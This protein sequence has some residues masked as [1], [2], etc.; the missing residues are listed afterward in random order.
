MGREYSQPVRGLPLAV[1]GAAAVGLALVGAPAWAACP[2]PA[3]RSD[4][5]AALDQVALARERGSPVGFEVA[6]REVDAVVGCLQEPLEA[7]LARELHR[8]HGRAREAAGL[9]KAAVPYLAAGEAR[10][11]PATEPHLAEALA[12][13]RA[14]RG[15]RLPPPLRGQLLVDGQTVDLRPSESEPFVFQHVVGERIVATRY[16][17]PGAELPAYA[18][19]RGRL[20]LVG[21]TSLLLSGGCL[22]VAGLEQRRLT[23]P[24]DTPFTAAELD[25]LQAR[26]QGFVVGAGVT[27]AV[28]LGALGALGLSFV[29]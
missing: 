23:Q 16:V 6:M 4:L 25:A 27:G 14:P 19:L 2:A 26:N 21:G 18:P 28:A 22:L 7:E 5:R 20:A 3:Y 1:R 8:L 12:G 11:D 13:W 17:H 10:P 24:R 9:R 15:P 29:W